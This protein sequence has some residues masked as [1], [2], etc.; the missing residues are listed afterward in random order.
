MSAHL[1]NWGR[2]R[3][4]HRAASRDLRGLEQAAPGSR[5]PFGNGRSYG[6]T[7]HNDRGLLLDRRGDAGIVSFDSETGRVRVRAGTLLGDL[8]AAVLPHGWFPAVVPGT[9]FVTVGGCFANDVH[10]KNHHRRGTFASHVS[11]FELVRSDG[12]G[13][14][15]R[16]DPMFRATA[17]GMGL[18]GVVTWLDL[19]LMRVEGG[20]IRQRAVPFGSLA[21]YLEQAAEADR[22]HEYSV[23]WLDAAS[24]P[25]HGVMLNGDHVEGEAGLRDR[26]RFS[27]PFQPPAT[28]LTR[29][30]IRT[31]NALYGFA[32]RRRAERIVP[33]GT[34]FWPLDGV[35][36]WNRLYGPRGLHQH[37]SVVPFGAEAAV[38]ELLEAA[39]GAGQT[40]F[41]TVLKRFGDAKAE[42]ALSFP[43]P[44]Y[45]LTLDFPH[46][47]Q[48]TLE[49]LD[50]LDAITLDAGG[51]TNAYKDS[52]MSAATFQRGYPRW[53]GGRGGARPGHHVR[54]LAPLRPPRGRRRA[55]SRSRTCRG[56]R[57]MT[58]LPFILFTVFTNA[59]AQI[60]LKQG[61]LGLGPLAPDGPTTAL[62]LVAL[63]F[64]V[65]FSPGSSSGSRPS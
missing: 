22:R 9:R 26:P 16:G 46:R 23:A 53:R 38:R 28:V 58:M 33:A 13:V 42:G 31:F 29:P 25:A 8:A 10:G 43:M 20:A 35:A 2:T 49:L 36:H 7:C 65:V 30:A 4:A 55:A 21:A 61:M 24:P 34:Y 40:S 3:R 6:D 15:K 62:S 56:G 14:V 39:R 52:R 50:R 17:G 27:V 18:T 5:L 59:A 51:R 37:Q 19:A 60:M 41:L 63:V 57:R 1:E 44:G 45:T 47:G 12:I 64:K 54:L 11:R 48:A 32:Q